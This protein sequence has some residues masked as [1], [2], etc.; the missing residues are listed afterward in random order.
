MDFAPC[1]DPAKPPG[2]FVPLTTGPSLELVSWQ[3]NVL[4]YEMTSFAVTVA[5]L[6]V[7]NENRVF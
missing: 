3:H 6:Q 7:G 5:T 1:I 2:H 4:F